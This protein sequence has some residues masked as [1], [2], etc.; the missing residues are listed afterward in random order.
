MK[1]N[2][3]ST[4]SNSRKREKIKVNENEH[5]EIE[6]FSVSTDVDFLFQIGKICAESGTNVDEGI[7]SLNDFCLILDYFHQ[8]MSEKVYTK[9]KTQ[10]KFYIGV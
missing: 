10:A 6:A 7:R 4:A 8:D 5:Y 9:M 1:Q 2:S 3:S